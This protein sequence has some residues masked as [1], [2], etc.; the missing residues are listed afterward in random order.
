M[1]KEI[2]WE[3]EK[4]ETEGGK[5]IEYSRQYDRRY[6]AESDFTSIFK[7]KNM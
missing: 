5:G 4:G 6:Q 1:R 3:K 7:I 2:E